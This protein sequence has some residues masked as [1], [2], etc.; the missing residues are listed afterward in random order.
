M[1]A[2]FKLYGIYQEQLNY[3]RQQITSKSEPRHI[4]PNFSKPLHTG[5]KNQMWAPIQMCYFIE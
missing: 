2:I 4:L 3:S 1:P 5:V